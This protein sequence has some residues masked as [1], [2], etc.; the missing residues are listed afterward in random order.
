VTQ[1]W[2][3][4]ISV[5]AGLLL[6]ACSTNQTTSLPRL[7]ASAAAIPDR[8]VAKKTL[9]L[10]YITDL[11]FTSQA[12]LNA[13]A[14]PLNANGPTTPAIA[15]GGG[16][17]GL[18]FESSGIAV[19]RDQS[20]ALDAQDASGGAGVNVYPPGATGNTPPS[21]IYSCPGVGEALSLAYD[22]SGVLYAMNFNP[23]RVGSNSIFVFPKGASSGCPAGTH[24]IFGDKT[25]LFGNPGGIAVANHQIYA[26]T[27]AVD[28]SAILEF[29]DSANGNKKPSRV[30][31]GSKTGFQIP[32]GIAVDASGEILVADSYA[33]TIDIFAADAHGNAAPI[34]IISGSRTGLFQPED[35][36]VSKN[37][38][39]FV[40]NGSNNTNVQG[41]SITVY[42]SKASGNAKPIQTIPGGNG[43]PQSEIG[44]PTAIA[45]F[46]P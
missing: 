36:T 45:L 46:E 26:V 10:V 6:A 12:T 4:R 1:S 15:L 34:R 23:P 30:I 11:W 41:D 39:I 7:P 31:T 8:R 29:P 28:T 35:V 14:Y 9:P 38:R 17:V 16:S 40:V 2:P 44:N 25:Q 24:T 19:S 21:A 37:G 3:F 22:A 33:N 42:A 18:E 13:V 5:A 32:V 43:Y 27:G 20:V